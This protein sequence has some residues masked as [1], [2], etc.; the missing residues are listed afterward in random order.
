MWAARKSRDVHRGG[1]GPPAESATRPRG[2]D[3]E[4]TGTQRLYVVAEVREPGQTPER[5]S[6]PGQG[7][8]EPG[9]RDSATGP[10]ACSS[11]AGDDPEDSSG[12]IQRSRLGHLIGAGASRISRSRPGATAAPDGRAPIGDRSGSD[13]ARGR[14]ISSRTALWGHERGDDL[15][16][17]EAPV[18]NARC[19]GPRRTRSFSRAP[20]RGASRPLP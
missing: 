5:H 14:T 13:R 11:A 8:R 3:S 15:L 7:D 20:L 17:G 18:E 4:R 2:V 16:D 12:K 9:P 19:S 1:R 10:R 6:A